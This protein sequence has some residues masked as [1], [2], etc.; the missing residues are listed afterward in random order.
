MFL[1]VQLFWVAI[2]WSTFPLIALHLTSYKLW[3]TIVQCYFSVSHLNL[4]KLWPLS[5]DLIF[6]QEAFHLRPS[7]PL[8]LTALCLMHSLP[9]LNSTNSRNSSGTWT[10]IACQTTPFK[11]I[12][13]DESSLMK[14]QTELTKGQSSHMNPP[15]CPHALPSFLHDRFFT[16]L[17]IPLEVYSSTFRTF[18]NLQND[19]VAATQQ[20]D[21]FHVDK[22]EDM[23]DFLDAVL[24]T[25]IMNAT[26][27]FLYSIG[28]AA[29]LSIMTC[30]S[31]HPFISSGVLGPSLDDLHHLLYDLWFSP[32]SR[33]VKYTT[34]DSSGFEHVFSGETR[35]T[36]VIGFHSW[37]KF[38][39]EERKGA[40]NY[41]GYIAVTEVSVP[42]IP[43]NVGI[44]THWLV[45]HSTA[46]SS[47]CPVLME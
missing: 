18:I 12:F 42:C 22:M 15:P 16:S 29:I 38:F 24:D 3:L 34:L 41:H 39:L 40:L 7:T 13:R 5:S 32:Y 26:H 17:D 14:P 37:I 1:S 46:K 28:T 20:E 8:A 19:F 36:K 35:G 27:S 21:P 2:S 4:N 45:V 25:P 33:K 31:W 44:I 10:L 43:P 9:P 47:H 23:E 30:L 6:F 11:S